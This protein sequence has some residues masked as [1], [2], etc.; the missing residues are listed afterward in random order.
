MQLALVKMNTAGI[1]EWGEDANLLLSD[2]WVEGPM[3][4]LNGFSN[5]GY[6]II[7]TLGDGLCVQYINHDG[8]L[9]PPSEEQY[10]PWANSEGLHSTVLNDEVYIARHDWKDD[11]ISQRMWDISIRKMRNITAVGINDEVI[12]SAS[13]A[14][15][16]YP[17]PFSNTCTINT[18][19]DSKS[20]STFE[21][22]NLR[23]QKI[24]TWKTDANPSDKTSSV[25]DGKDFKGNRVGSG[26]YFVR[27]KSGKDT[28]VKKILKLGK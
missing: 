27:V 20:G 11:P 23:G 15:S 2:D 13:D 14:I 17:N 22:Y 24:N 16:C 25:W 19:L 3:I 10:I 9:V 21:V 12:P 26:V 28:F 5:N 8:T 7:Y 4:H 6:A 1:H 18:N